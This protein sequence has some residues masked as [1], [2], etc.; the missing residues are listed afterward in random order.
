MYNFFTFCVLYCLTVA[1]IFQTPILLLSGLHANLKSKDRGDL[2][3]LAL[4]AP[5]I[6]C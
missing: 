1:P 4:H 3:A 5:S 2:T 6:A